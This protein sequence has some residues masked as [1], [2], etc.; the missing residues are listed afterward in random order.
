MWTNS[1]FIALADLRHQLRARETLMW[2][3]LMPIV[4]FY[5]IGTVTG[6]FGGGGGSAK[7]R[8]VLVV[9]EGGGFLVDQ[10]QRR[11]EDR[12]YEVARALPSDPVDPDQTR[13]TIPECFT[14]RVLA[15]E[16]L[17][18]SLVHSEAGLGTNYDRIRVGRAVYTVLADLVAATQAGREPSPEAFDELEQQPRALTLEVKPAGKRKRVPVGFEQT[19]PGTMVMFTLIVL[20]TSGS[21]LLVIERHGGLLKRLASTPISRGE[22]VLGKWLG[23]MALA[24]VQIAFAM[25]AGSLLFKID[26]RPS[27]GMVCAVL[28]AWAALAASLAMLAGSLARS[29][30]QAIALGVLT[31]NVLAALGGCWWPIEI[32]PGWMQK[33]ALFLPTGW[34]MDALHQL[35]IFDAGWASAMP[36]VLGLAC[37]ALVVGWF[38][39]RAFRYQ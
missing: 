30:G 36:H 28:F 27:F 13:L 8:L 1:R 37:L 38:A 19:I 3:F 4:F 39:T 26:W 7:E 22:V 32:T 9:P 10:L 6:G 34:A 31:S 12:K 29:E 15:G 5:F 33:L 24:L 2:V 35:L 16:R 20:L 23:R 18:L 11:L 25:L 14:E 21:V 17:E